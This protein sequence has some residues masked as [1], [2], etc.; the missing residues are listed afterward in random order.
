MK[1]IIIILIMLLALISFAYAVPPVTTVSNT[2][3][4]GLELKVPIVNSVKLNRNFEFEVH[5]FN[6]TNGKPI[7]KDISCYLHLYNSTG[8]HI[9]E[10]EDS[11]VSHQFDYSFNVPPETF[12]YIGEY[13]LIVQCNNSAV[14]GFF[15]ETLYTIRTENKEP[16]TIAFIISIISISF[17]LMI[18][19]FKLDEEHAI[20][21]LILII[22]SVI[23]L[24]LIPA[25]FV[26]ENIDLTF[27]KIF[28]GFFILFWIYV[29]IYTIYKGLLH[30]G[31]IVIPPK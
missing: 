23:I 22:F 8:Q 26:S 17:F 5:V 14:G 30:Y 3:A 15:A 20:L 2:G 31:V 10:L 21:K 25:A 16:I 7:I 12:I 13:S 6:K 11:T 19:A 9:V 4:T 1:K 27:Y 28:L 29:L 18:L 24:F